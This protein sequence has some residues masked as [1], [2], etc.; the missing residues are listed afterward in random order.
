MAD[1]DTPDVLVSDLGCLRLDWPKVVFS[2]M[3]R[4][5]VDLENL[6][7][8]CRE[9][10]GS[11]QSGLCTHCG[12][13][14][15]GDLGRHV[16]HFHLDL[17]QLWRYPVTWCTVWRGT[18]QDCVD[19]MRRAH[20]VPASI[21]ATNLARWFPPW[22]VSRENWNTVLRSSVSGVATDT[23]LFSRIGVPLVHRYRIFARAG[24][25]VA[26]RGTYMARLRTFLTVAD[27]AYLKSRDKRHGQ[28]LASQM[29][30]EVPGR[31][32]SRE[33]TNSS[34]PST[35]RHLRRL[36]QLLSESCHLPW[37]VH[38]GMAVGPP[39][40][41]WISHCLVARCTTECSR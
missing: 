25:H 36:L 29:S 18:P 28:S 38:T 32:R 37:F 41:R 24:T 22:T 31:S 4:Y 7:H 1:A 17:A 30:P 9:R 16:A 40:S 3:G 11:V 23:L 8:E 27:A 20:T 34:Q 2:Y 19:H 5:Q 13:Y 33:L 14:I 35:S 6:R 21:R 26:F 12:K 39:L 15:C 10:F